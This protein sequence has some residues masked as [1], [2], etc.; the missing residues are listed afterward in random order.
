[1][2]SPPIRSEYF[3]V[4]HISI[5]VRNITAHTIKCAARPVIFYPGGKE[6]LVLGRNGRDAQCWIIVSM[7]E[8]DGTSNQLHVGWWG[9]EKAKKFTLLWRRTP[10][11][12][13]LWPP[14]P[15]VALLDKGMRVTK[16]GDE[17]KIWLSESESA[18]FRG[19]VY[20][21]SQLN[22]CNGDYGS[23]SR[24]DWFIPSTQLPSH[25]MG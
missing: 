2:P 12:T 11:L 8:S 3:T 5:A 10:D 17:K 7:Q 15:I 1:M 18:I 14:S 6:C 23:T 4:F 22:G 16:T 21:G 20:W 13:E 9:Y 25:G 19:A 24:F